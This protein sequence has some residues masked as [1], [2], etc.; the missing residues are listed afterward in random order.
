MDAN[1]SSLNDPSQLRTRVV[2]LALIIV[3]VVLGLSS[4]KF[5]DALPGFV[6]SY[7]GDTLWALMVFLGVSLLVPDCPVAKRGGIAMVFSYLIEI[8]QFYHAPWI[9]SLRETTLGGLILGFGFLWSDL[10][11]YSVG[12]VFGVVVDQAVRKRCDSLV[13][14]TTTKG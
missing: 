1:L 11:C 13:I 3:V 6:A 5:G 12:V 10:L 14:E 8:S 9:D 7:A 2:Y 4:R